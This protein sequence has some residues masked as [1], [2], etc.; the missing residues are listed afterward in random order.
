MARIK[1][2]NTRLDF[3]DKINLT[4]A[5]TEFQL[6][7]MLCLIP[8]AS[9][10][11]PS[12]QRLEEM[13]KGVAMLRGSLFA[14]SFGLTRSSLVTRYTALMQCSRTTDTSDCTL[15]KKQYITYGQIEDKTM[16]ASTMMTSTDFILK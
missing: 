6:V 13:D 10:P 16:I 1:V 15:Q 3:S 14:R 12:P 9:P 11:Y 2:I 4:L 5:L 7:G 8:W